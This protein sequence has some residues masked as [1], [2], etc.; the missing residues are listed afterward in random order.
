MTEPLIEKQGEKLKVPE[1]ENICAFHVTPDGN[2]CSDQFTINKMKEFIKNLKGPNDEI[3]KA[4]AEQT[5]ELAKQV[6][7]CDNEACILKN[8]QFSQFIGP[9]QADETLQDRFKPA[10]P[11]NNT[12]WLNNDNIDYVLEQWAK[13]YPGFVHVPFQ[14]IDFDVI[15]TE[16][17]RIDLCQVYESGMKKLG[18]VINTDRSTG[19]G[20]HWF[21]IFIDMSGPEWTLEYFDS[22]GEYPKTSVHKWLNT[23]RSLLATKHPDKQ[24]KVV[25]VTR[26]NQLQKSTTECGVFSLWYILSRL[27]GIPYT[28]FSQPNAIDDKMMYDFRKFLFRHEMKKNG[29]ASKKHK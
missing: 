4:D 14:M 12:E 8:A 22:A 16:L 13:K 18:C 11:A 27:S 20:I 5:V 25:D 23:Q 29:G 15:G 2:V 10:G 6:T 21:C 3:D 9:I 1:A 26:S 17:S 24:I 28:Y 19:R 7:S